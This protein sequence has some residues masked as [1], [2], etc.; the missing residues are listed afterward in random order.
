MSQ[1]LYILPSLLTI[2]LKILFDLHCIH[3]ILADFLS[4]GIVDHAFAYPKIW[5]LV[6]SVAQIP[7]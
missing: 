3:I 4:Q 7:R 6:F 5:Y 2:L 1:R